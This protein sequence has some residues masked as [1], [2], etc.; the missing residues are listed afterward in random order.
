MEFTLSDN[1]EKMGYFF[2][3]E[4]REQGFYGTLKY[5]NGGVKIHVVRRQE[6]PNLIDSVSDHKVL[7]GELSDGTAV[8]LQDCYTLQTKNS[9]LG[10]QE[11]EILA[12][13][14]LVNVNLEKY[15][16]EAISRVRLR[17]EHLEMWIND[18]L[19]RVEEEHPSVFLDTTIPRVKRFVITSN[20]TLHKLG[21][22]ITNPNNGFYAKTMKA[23]PYIDIEY[24]LR[25]ASF[26]RVM[27]DVF[28]VRNFL[29]LMYG[30]VPKCISIKVFGDEKPLFGID[31]LGMIND[32]DLQYAD[33]GNPYQFLLHRK[34]YT[35]YYRKIV[36]T[37]N[38]KYE[39]LLP[40]LDL[41]VSSEKGNSYN[42]NRFLMTARALEAYHRKIIKGNYMTEDEWKP[43]RA[44][45][46]TAISKAL[47]SGH[48]ASIKSRIRYAYQ[49]SF[50]KRLTDIQ[51]QIP[52][53]IWQRLEL[54]ISAVQNRTGFVLAL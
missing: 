16:S 41:L 53:E 4:N 40:I 45:L 39:E 49:F 1:F 35:Q 20:G 14:L 46:S 15:D 10:V 47:D 9:M 26:S 31:I 27:D 44:E 22:T 18:N 24:A 2:N 34:A 17:F 50:R 3:P 37:W 52:D 38:D 12:V 7:Y 23:S 48:R 33:I 54:D 36:N 21:W 30:D 8:R 43:Y 32:P 25:K 11:I 5:S 29:Y 42:E 51:K 19:F 28:S 13:Y 6:D